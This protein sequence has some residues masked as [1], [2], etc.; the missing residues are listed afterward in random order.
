MKLSHIIYIKNI[1]HKYMLENT[2]NSLKYD[3]SIFKFELN[4]L[5]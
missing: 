2:L 3:K 4:D 1:I 5:I